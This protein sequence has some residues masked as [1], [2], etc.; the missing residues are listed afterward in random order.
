[1]NSLP[2]EMLKMIVDQVP[3]GKD[4]RNIRALNRTFCALSTPR[5]FRRIQVRNT[6]WHTEAFENVVQ[7]KAAIPYLE[8]IVFRDI[9]A[10]EDGNFLAGVYL[11]RSYHVDPGL[12]EAVQP[13][14]LFV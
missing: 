10:G 14:P 7:S 5:V 9:Y 1:M 3:A 13:L 6:I 12:N 8:E 4:L 11:P 2:V